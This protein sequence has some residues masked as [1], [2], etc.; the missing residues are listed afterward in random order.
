M[1]KVLPILLII[2]L[3][4]LQSFSLGIPDYITDP[5]E[6]IFTQPVAIQIY[7]NNCKIKTGIDHFSE[8]KNNV[9]KPIC[10]VVK[11]SD[12]CQEIPKEDLLTCSNYKENNIDLYSLDFLFGCAKGLWKSVKE[13]FI[14]IK[15]AIEWVYDT[16]TKNS[17]RSKI[18]E[19][20]Q[21]TYDIAMNYLAVEFEKAKEDGLSDFNAGAKV[22]KKLLSQIFNRIGK[23]IKEEF[24]QFGC[25][26]G[27]AKSKKTCKFV[28]DIFFLQPLQ[29]VC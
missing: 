14:F 5:I 15:D 3:F 6:K 7:E 20:A 11:A 10:T 25:L 19:S 2:L 1:K 24:N 28:G 29:L 9:W 13:F 18:K 4:P 22:A 21:K 17:Q 8:V 23:I 16:A 12:E 27:K 26:N